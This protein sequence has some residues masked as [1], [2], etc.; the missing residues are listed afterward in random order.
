M[1]W[2]YKRLVVWFALVS[3]LVGLG[4]TASHPESTRAQT[5]SKP[6]VSFILT[7]DFRKDDL[8][9]SYMPKIS[10]IVEEQCMM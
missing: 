10:T 6:N 8:N 3:M 2:G 1:R 5:A 7:D 4:M 9:V